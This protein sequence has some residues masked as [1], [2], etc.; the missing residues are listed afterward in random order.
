MDRDRKKGQGN[1]RARGGERGRGG[2]QDAPGRGTSRPIETPGRGTPTSTRAAAERRGR[3]RGEDIPVSEGGRGSQPSG[4]E[5]RRSSRQFEDESMRR[6]RVRDDAE[7]QSMSRGQERSGNEQW[8]APGDTMR[9]LAREMTRAVGNW[10]LL[11][12]QWMQ[13][14]AIEVLERGGQMV[15]RAELPGMRKED[16]RVRVMDGALFLEGERRN[17]QRQEREDYYESEWS[18]GHFAR[19]IPL[20]GPV[21]PDEVKARF[22]NGVLE[23]TLPVR[24]PATQDVPIESGMAGSSRGR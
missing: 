14:P 20:P 19:R 24:T 4:E 15:V 21:N 13:W 9:R 7:R 12:A 3:G 6:R 23:I 17:E 18:Y 22:E 5:G 11:P 2:R 10:G 8:L 1:V 16:V